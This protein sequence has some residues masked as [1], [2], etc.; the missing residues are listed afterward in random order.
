[1]NGDGVHRGDGKKMT[2]LLEGKVYKTSISLIPMPNY[3]T[4]VTIIVAGD[5]QKGTPP[6]W[7]V[8]P[9]GVKIPKH[10][11]KALSMVL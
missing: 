9:A 10:K 8:I 3:K 11:S 1:M 4:N 6:G 2:R 7:R 5:T